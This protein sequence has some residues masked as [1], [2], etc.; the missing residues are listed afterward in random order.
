MFKIFWVG[1]DDNFESLNKE[2]S[3]KESSENDMWQ[4]AM[5]IIETPDEIVIVSPIAWID[6]DDIDLSLDK[7]VLTIKWTRNRPND[8]YEG[9][10]VTLRNSECFWWDFVRNVILPDNLDFESVKAS[11]ENNMLVINIDKLKFPSQNI[12][13]NKLEW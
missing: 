10:W 9:K 7:S 5:D 4:L 2:V 8:L 3:E 12:K 1:D 6:L 13:I 11:M